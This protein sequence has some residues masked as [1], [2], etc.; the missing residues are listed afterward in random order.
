M[1]YS[2]PERSANVTPHATEH[3]GE[4]LFAV[5]RYGMMKQMKKQLLGGNLT[6]N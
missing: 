3:P 4:I 1:S 6:T 5:N 2:E